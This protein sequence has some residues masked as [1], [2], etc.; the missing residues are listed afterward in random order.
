MNNLIIAGN[1]IASNTYAS[2]ITG[3]GGIGFNNLYSSS[4]VWVSITNNQVI[5]NGWGEYGDGAMAGGIGNISASNTVN[6]LV[7]NNSI[8]SNVGLRSGGFGSRDSGGEITFTNNTVRNNLVYADYST[9]YSY[10]GPGLGLTDSTTSLHVDGSYFSGNNTYAGNVSYVGGA[11]GI[12]WDLNYKTTTNGRISYLNFV[13]NVVGDNWGG[14]LS[15][16]GA[17]LG[18]NGPRFS[19]EGGILVSDNIFSNSAINFLGMEGIY[20]ATTGTMT[21]FVISQNSFRNAT[22]PGGRGGP[23][24]IMID[25][26][27]NFN[28]RIRFNYIE[29]TIESCDSVGISCTNCSTGKGIGS[30]DGLG[31]LTIYNNSV[32]NVCGAGIQ[33]R[34]MD[35][36]AGVYSAT[37]LV[38]SNYIY[39]VGKANLYD[40]DEVYGH[41]I[42]MFGNA[43][44]GDLSIYNNEIS[45]SGHSGI[46][47]RSNDWIVIYSNTITKHSLSGIGFNS[48]GSIGNEIIISRNSIFNNTNTTTK[49]A[50]GIGFYGFSDGIVSIANN[51]IDNNVGSTGGIGLKNVSGTFYV[52]DNNTITNNSSQATGSGGFG[53][54]QLSDGSS[55]TIIN[56]IVTSNSSTQAGGIG[57][58]N[59]AGDFYVSNNTVRNND[60]SAGGSGGIGLF[61]VSSNSDTTITNNLVDNNI[62]STGG[63]GFAD[64]DPSLYI[65]S[66]SI[67]NNDGDVVGGIGITNSNSTITLYNNQIISNPKNGIGFS[68]YSG[69]SRI[70]SNLIRHQHS[71]RTGH[72]TNSMGIGIDHPEQAYFMIENNELISNATA[73]GIIGEESTSTY[74][75]GLTFRNNHISADKTAN[76]FGIT[77][78]AVSFTGGGLLVDNNDE[79]FGFHYLWEG[80]SLGTDVVGKINIVNG[81][82]FSYCIEGFKSDGGNKDINIENILEDR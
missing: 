27:T 20:S 37:N 48:G 1:Y 36:E 15:I 38:Y 34:P 46:G 72:S 28:N 79:N 14:A 67:I 80:V 70:Y 16:S 60:S 50:G 53:A 59:S 66:N 57:Y 32:V 18:D 82:L 13:N 71:V 5:N 65:A 12:F 3:I 6:W 41:G 33:F 23:A 45:S 29:D 40:G 63:I 81:N 78:K 55:I 49:G 43:D 44:N 47:V 62:G 54:S 26:T 76:Y 19:L 2:S 31:L 61:M 11:V 8:N 35:G 56:N 25:I 17:P 52:V 64:S 22:G 21:P 77:G 73:L 42:G 74:S 24:S 9:N 4:S 75:C 51:V 10:M 7:D 68:Y 69:S 58:Q 30:Q 39:N